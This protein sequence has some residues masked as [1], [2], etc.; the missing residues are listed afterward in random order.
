[1]KTWCRALAATGVAVLVGL[2]FVPNASAQCGGVRLPGHLGEAGAT[3]ANWYLPAG[4]VRLVPAAFA[5]AGD[6][7]GEEAGI[8]GFWHFKFV[9]QGSAGIPDGTEVDAGYTQWHSDGTEIT[10][11]GGHAPITSS[12][13]LG[14][15]K[16]TGEHSYQLSHFAIAWDATGANLVGPVHL[17]EQVTV[18]ADRNSYSGPFTTDVYD[19]SGNVLAHIQGTVTGTR[20][21]VDT[22]T[23]SIF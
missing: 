20:I 14:V 12:F 1:M 9:S 21:T 16:Q 10:N 6:R 11:S 7:G 22:P 2:L 4:E 15:W 18:S 23:Q 5:L 17:Q 19:E 13:C 8:V 3:H